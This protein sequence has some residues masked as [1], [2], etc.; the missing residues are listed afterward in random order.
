MFL[1]LEKALSYPQNSLQIPSST[2]FSH[3]RWVQLMEHIPQASLLLQNSMHSAVT[4]VVYPKTALPV[5]PLI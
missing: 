1:F 3:P 2:P 4:K 5:F